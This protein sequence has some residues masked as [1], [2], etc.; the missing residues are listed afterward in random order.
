L[1]PV[2]FSPLPIFTTTK[3]IVGLLV[4]TLLFFFVFKKTK[5]PV[6]ENLFYILWF[7]LFL[8]PNFL[9]VKLDDIDY[10]DHR[11]LLPMIGVL[12]FILSVFPTST[13]G[14]D[15]VSISGG[16]DFIWIGAVIVLSMVSISKINVYRDPKSYYGTVIKYNPQN[17]TVYNNR[18][19]WKAYIAG[20][21]NGALDDYNKAI[22]HNK[23]YV[24]AYLNRGALK[25]IIGDSAG[26]MDDFN[27]AIFHDTNNANAYL[28]R[29]LLKLQIE[30]LAGAIND[31][32]YA[33]KLNNDY[34]EA[35]N[36]RAA[37][38]GKMGNY[39][40]SLDDANTALRIK[41]D[42][43]DAYFNRASA[44]YLLNDYSNALQDC[45]RALK[46]DPNYESALWL[47]NLIL[48]NNN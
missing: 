35:Y 46:I 40:E 45:E 27:Q 48:N 14:K 15:K 3:I 5:R 2:D 39:H 6:R 47:K 23:E 4:L 12:L 9:G 37:T 38:K 8:F 42:L 7:F 19:W 20:D 13:K 21:A 24:L 11:F 36:D 44:H 32:D 25:S 16:K 28:N 26:A 33:I 10:I 17:A 18:G 30:D 41:P 1:F 31:F 22:I 43:K 34:A 29:G